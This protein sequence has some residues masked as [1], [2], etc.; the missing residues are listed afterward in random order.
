MS[1]I[2]YVLSQ[3][4]SNDPPVG[5]AQLL[6]LVYDELR[7]L[8][9]AYLAQERPGLTLDA[10]GLVHE[11]Y[12]KLAGGAQRASFQD[13]R[14]FFAAAATAMRQILV[15]NAR[16][17][18]AN[19]RG[20]H[21]AREPLADVPAKTP[22]DELLALHEALDRLAETDAVKAKL[23]ELRY[24]VGLTGDEAA[25]VLEISPTTA[26]RY[27]VFARAWLQNEVRGK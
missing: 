18:K 23:V 5:A 11:A 9:A 15:D 13:Q 2:I 8:A 4:E 6:P 21:L 19:K 16:R 27:W 22:A 26:D 7:R 25:Q 20:G 17:R 1:D 10:T 12:L 14:H 24:F 3:T